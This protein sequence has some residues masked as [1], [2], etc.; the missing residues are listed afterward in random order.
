MRRATLLLLT[1]A[2]HCREAFGFTTCIVTK[3]VASQVQGIV[4]LESSQG[5]WSVP[6]AAV[7]LVSFVD[8]ERLIAQTKTDQQGR[9]HIPGIPSGR[10]RLKVS[11]PG[12]LS[13]NVEIRI[14]QRRVI[15]LPHPP[16]FVVALALPLD[17][18]PSVR[19]YT[20]DDELPRPPIGTRRIDR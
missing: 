12:L 2:L 4:L 3:A 9:F 19:P 16:G 18:C 7:Q 8:P 6:A 5:E 11:S 15:V 13:A 17:T 14:R 10:Y 1:F 20:Q